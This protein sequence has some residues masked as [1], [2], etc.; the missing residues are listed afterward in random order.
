MAPA[1]HPTTTNRSFFTLC[2]GKL[3]QHLFVVCS[4]FVLG[5]A[6]QSGPHLC[7]TC[8]LT[9]DQNGNMNFQSVKRAVL[10]PR[11]CLWGN[12]I[13]I[14]TCTHTLRMDMCGFSLSWKRLQSLTMLHCSICAVSS[15][16]TW[17]LWHVHVL[18]QGA[19]HFCTPPQTAFPILVC[20]P[21]RTV[22]SPSNLFCWGFLR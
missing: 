22:L 10:F 12:K 11:L 2:H 9:Q 16:K 5:C 21:L 7:N 15:D 20:T 3:L 13:K 4:N 1:R 8:M 6:L 19:K 14:S 17:L 18:M